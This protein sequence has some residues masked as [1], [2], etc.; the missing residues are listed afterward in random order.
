MRRGRGPCHH[1]G[2]C[3]YLLLGPGRINRRRKGERAIKKWK[4]RRGWFTA[5]EG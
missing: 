1:V 3:E 4:K 2:S 5:S